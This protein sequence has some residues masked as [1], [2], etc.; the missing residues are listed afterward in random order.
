MD[1]RATVKGGP[2]ARGGK[3]RVETRAVDHDVQPAAPVTPVGMF[4]QASDA[5]FFSAVTSNVTSACL[6]D[7]LIE[8]WER[9]RERFPH[10]KTLL[11]NVDNGPEHHRRRT[12]CMQRLLE[13]V[14][15]DQITVRL[16]SYPPYH[17]RYNPV[18]RCWGDVGAALQWFLARLRRCSHPL[19]QHNDLQRNPSR[20]RM[21]DQALSKTPEKPT[22]SDRPPW[23][24]GVWISRTALQIF[25]GLPLQC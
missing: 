11:M 8:W 16:A 22:F 7:R 24:K 10:I 2:F 14:E 6:V 23:K 19:C 21:G 12:R 9:D 1:A 13:C 15:R 4:L 5:L 20:R 3:R 18:E 17:R 25:G